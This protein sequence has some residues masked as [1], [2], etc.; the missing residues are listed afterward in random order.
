[1]FRLKMNDDLVGK[2]YSPYLLD[3]ISPSMVGSYLSCPLSFYYK[4]I[5]KIKLPEENLHLLFG[6]AVHKVIEDIYSGKENPTEAFHEIFQ[7][8]KLDPKSKL[9]FFEY[10]LLGE[11]MLKNYQEVYPLLDSMFGLADGNSELRF[12]MKIVNPVSKEESTLPLSGIVDRYCNNGRIIE[13]KTSATKWHA[14][15]RRFKIQSR[16][17]SLW[18]FTQYG[19]F[20]TEVIYIVL[21]KKYKKTA[22]DKVYQIITY[23]PTPD[24]LAEAWEEVEYVIDKIEAGIFDRPTKGHMPFCDCY[25]F[26]AFLGVQS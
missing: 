8:H 9:R 5:A 24:D 22:R 6:S 15:E 13:Y 4:N 3:R 23:H 12:R 2:E 18:Y 20:P 14:D 7:Q 16:L 1:M 26:E 17:Y 10:S 11:E 25:K 21:L 19:K